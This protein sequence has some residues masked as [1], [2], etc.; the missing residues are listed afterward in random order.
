MKRFLTAEDRA[1][2]HE[3]RM[4]EI[5]ALRA[6]EAMN[7]CKGQ[8]GTLAVAIAEATRTHRHPQAPVPTEA[9]VIACA[10]QRGLC[11]VQYGQGKIDRFV[12]PKYVA[13]YTEQ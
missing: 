2:Q 10:Q 8:Y 7:L 11:H 5:R 1:E 4:E 9:E 13:F 6:V 12:S 3:A